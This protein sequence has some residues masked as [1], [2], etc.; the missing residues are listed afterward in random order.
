MI[1]RILPSSVTSY[2]VRGDIDDAA[3][4]PEE[5]MVIADAPIA[6]CRE[7]TTARVCAHLRLTTRTG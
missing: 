6:R 7:V 5:S 4:L 1:A 2:K 3:L